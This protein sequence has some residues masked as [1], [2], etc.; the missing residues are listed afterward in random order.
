MTP[1][2]ADEALQG[3]HVEAA[4]GPAQFKLPTPEAIVHVRQFELMAPVVLMFGVTA[5]R[6]VLRQLSPITQH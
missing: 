3:G 5:G 4:P 2:P 6:Y 1:N